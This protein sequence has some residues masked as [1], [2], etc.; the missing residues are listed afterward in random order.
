MNIDYN[1]QNNTFH[2]YNSKLSY[3]ISV[4]KNQ[5]LVTQYF[6]KRIRSFNMSRRHWQYDRGFLSNPDNA[7][8]EFSLDV[9]L[10][11]YPD[12]F[13]GDF[14][15]AAYRIRSEDGDAVTRFKFA[16]HKIYCGKQDLSGLPQVDGNENDTLTLEIYLLDDIRNLKIILFY[17]IYEDVAVVTRSVK[18][19]NDSTETIC[20]EKLLSM[21]IDFLDED[22]EVLTLTG[23]HLDEKRQNRRAILSDQIRVESTRGTSS[24]QATPFIGLLKPQSN[25]FVGDCVGITMMYSGSFEATIQKAQFGS[26]RT[27]I[28]INSDGFSWVSNPSE[29]LDVPEAII[30]FSDEGTNG[31]SNEFHKLFESRV[32]RPQFR[33]R[34]RPI[35][36]NTWE[37]F[38]NAIDETKVLELA[39]VSKDLGFELLVIDDGWFKNRNSDASG[40]GDWVV[41]GEKFPSGLAALSKQIREMGLEFGLWFEP[42]MVSKDSNLFKQ[43]PD[44]VICSHRYEPINSRNQ[45]VLNLGINDV[46]NYLFEKISTIIIESKATYIKWDMNRHLTDLFSAGLSNSQQGELSFRYTLGLYSLLE[47]LNLCFPD[48]LFENCSSGGGRLDPGMLRY[49]PQAWVSDNTDA[50]GRL[51][52]Q[53]GTSILFPPSILGNHVSDT[54]NHQVGRITPIQTRFNVASLGVLG[55]ELD[56]TSLDDKEKFII[57]SQID[58]YKSYK[59]LFQFGKFF[60]L[61]A[62]NHNYNAWQIVSKNGDLTAL[63]VIQKLSPNSYRVPIIKLAGLD[64]ESFYENIE[65]GEVFGGDELMFSGLSFER[66]RTDFHSWLKIFK[67][68]R[69]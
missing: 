16:G 43:H 58:F 57:K 32:I 64:S 23:S 18:F 59:S 44:W 14:R 36:I 68:V 45:F 28:G 30:A 53:E 25:E 50:I 49:M 65:S 12:T 11:E 19:I 15:T 40:L 52:I 24:P 46:Q 9:I 47:K 66:V 67:K 37:S 10:R 42:E 63:I 54:P 22:W 61:Y 31:L 51:D 27:Q 41:D 55:Y 69:N 62:P 48:V 6:G 29:S 34:E 39:K 4:E 5:F 7:D 33:E 8:K 3:V 38:Y 1:S 2:L 26:I 21:N 13:Q 60:R 56:L 20:V 17:N 35:L